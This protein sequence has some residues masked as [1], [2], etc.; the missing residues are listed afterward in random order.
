MSPKSV[1]PQRVHDRMSLSR[2]IGKSGGIPLP[3]PPGSMSVHYHKSGHEMGHCFSS[4]TKNRAGLDPGMRQAIVGPDP[5]Y[6]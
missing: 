4:L 1:H 2:R 5:Y 6:P 3:K